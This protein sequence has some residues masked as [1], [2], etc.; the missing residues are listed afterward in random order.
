MS[1]ASGDE[2]WARV[3]SGAC[4]FAPSCN[5]GPRGRKRSCSRSTGRAGAGGRRPPSWRSSCSSPIASGTARSQSRPG[6]PTSSTPPDHSTLSRTG[7]GQARP[8]SGASR[9][10]PRASSTNRW[11]TPR[12][13]AR[14]SC[15]ARAGSSS[16][17]WRRG[18]PPRCARALVAVGAAATRSSATP[19]AP[20]A[21]TSRSD[22][23][24]GCQRAVRSRRRG[25][26]TTE[27]CMSPPCGNTTTARPNG[28]DRGTCP[29]LIR[30]SAFHTM[31]HAWEMED[32]DLTVPA[33]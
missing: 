30:H 20:R 15:C 14:L 32:K 31:D 1:S 10:L 13:T 27:R 11:M 12:S 26:V 2:G 17:R 23:G 29:F 6:W 33:G 25:C 9:S 28:C 18:C 22:W 5:V 21:R 8:T 3:R 16:T 7:L 24:C 4:P 19:S